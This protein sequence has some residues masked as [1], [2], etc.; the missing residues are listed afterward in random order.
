[1]E[2]KATNNDL[3][4][5]EKTREPK[6]ILGKDDFLLLMI[7]QL[8][9]QDPSS[10]MDTDQFMSQM[11]Q[12]TMMEQI[13]NM[14]SQITDLLHSQQINQG[15]EMIGKTVTLVDPEG[16]FTGVVEKIIVTN[17]TV[18]VVVDGYAYDI[19]Q[20]AIVE[21]KAAQ[22]QPPVTESEMDKVEAVD[23]DEVDTAGGEDS[24]Q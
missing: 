12:F 1:V 3:F 14:N 24:D 19:N 20:I 6:Q 11:A 5:P 23:V 10:P 17:N 13:T 18:K 16:E 2:V 7:E 9:N 15:A 21:G 8:K 4:L 22:E